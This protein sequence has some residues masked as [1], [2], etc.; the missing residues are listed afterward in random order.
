MMN[1]VQVRK[2]HIVVVKLNALR[3]PVIVDSIS[4][5]TG[6]SRL[7]SNAM[8][9]H[10]RYSGT[11]VEYMTLRAKNTANMQISVSTKTVGIMKGTHGLN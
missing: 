11:Y 5:V 10:T 8:K 7:S 4:F 2:K 3:V 1:E 6:R 9:E